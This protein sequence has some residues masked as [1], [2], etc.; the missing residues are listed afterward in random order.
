MENRIGRLRRFLPPRTGISACPDQELSQPVQAD[1]NTPRKS[2]GYLTPT[3]IYSNQ[4][5][6]LK[7]ESTFPRKRE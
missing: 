4:V 5:L 3:E 1:N 2:L 7:C 6:H